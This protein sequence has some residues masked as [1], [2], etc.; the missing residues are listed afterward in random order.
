[1]SVDNGAVLAWLERAL[2]HASAKR[3]PEL[4]AY[5]EAVKEEMPFETELATGSP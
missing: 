4:K 5:L 2:E 1:M 3:S